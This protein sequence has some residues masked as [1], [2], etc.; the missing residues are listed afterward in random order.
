MSIF[1]FVV[2]SSS[3]FSLPIDQNCSVK[4]IFGELPAIIDGEPEKARLLRP[5]A[6]CVL[7]NILYFSEEDC[8]IRTI[9]L[10]KGIVKTIAGLKNKAG[11]SDGSLVDARFNGITAIVTDGKNLYVSERFNQ[12]IRKIDLKKGLVSTI[13]GKT[14]EKGNLDGPGNLARFNQPFSL[15]CDVKNLYIGDGFNYSIRMLSLETGMVSTLA[16]KA[17][18]NGYQDGKGENARFGIIGGLVCEG[19]DLYVI[20][21]DNKAVRRIDISSRTVTTLAGG[22]SVEIKDINSG[23]TLQS[24][25]TCALVEKKLYITEPDTGIIGAID[26]D[27]G[28]YSILAGADESRKNGS[29]VPSRDGTGVDARFGYVVGIVAYKGQ[30]YITDA[31]D[32]TIRT[33]TLND[34]VVKTLVGKTTNNFIVHSMAVIDSYLYFTTHTDA[35]IKRF[36]LLTQVVENYAGNSEDPQRVDGSLF[37]SRFWIPQFMVSNGT[38]IYLCDGNLRKIDTKKSSVSTLS[39]INGP[40]VII[41]DTLYVFSNNAIYSVNTFTGKTTVIAGKPGVAGVVDGY[42]ESARFQRYS[43]ITTD[44]TYIYVIDSFIR[45][46]NPLDFEVKTISRKTGLEICC[47][48][49]E[50]MYVIQ[51]HSLGIFDLNTGNI[52]IIAGQKGVEGNSDGSGTKALF[53]WPQGLMVFNDKLYLSTNKTIREID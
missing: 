8:V 42:G 35:S 12:T 17:K 16:G 34:L 40:L 31:F 53:S 9:D 22:P 10:E 7:D 3:V 49:N 6:L 43:S 28:R 13:A 5:W 11:S 29:R 51:L 44:G 41:N 23:S 20:D 33:I 52:N 27:T 21:G 30:L 39:D 2:I 36:N 50:H 48:S 19:K 18:S 47:W 32:S 26:I 46:I 25:N 15:A 38:D 1:I 4:T 37:E 24:M 14:K 45:R